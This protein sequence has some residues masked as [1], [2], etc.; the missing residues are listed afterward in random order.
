MLAIFQLTIDAVISPLR[1]KAWTKPVSRSAD[2]TCPTG[3]FPKPFSESQI[4]KRE[5][6]F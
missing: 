5:D 1:M 4:S 6:F 3:N 2:L